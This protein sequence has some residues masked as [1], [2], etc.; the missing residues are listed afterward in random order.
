MQWNENHTKVL[1]TTVLVL[2]IS[3]L[4]FFTQVTQHHLHVVY[5]ELYFLPIIFAGLW[6]GFQGGLLTALSITALY[7][8]FIL[9]H[10]QGFS[11]EDLDKVAEVVLYN[12][13]GI[14]VGF[15]RD[16]ELAREREKRETIQAMAGAV[17]HELNTPLFIVLGTAKLI[18]ESAEEG[19]ELHEDIRTIIEN[20]LTMKRLVK[21]IARIEQPS[22]TEY[23]GESK[24]VNIHEPS[25]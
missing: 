11:A 20:T 2:G 24:I 7:V 15:L 25:S 5:R 4:H 14:T 22:L 13:I 18:Q 19:T 10:W 23:A 8:P 1:I 16:R 12:V 6:F 3:L 21:K 17:A 9:L